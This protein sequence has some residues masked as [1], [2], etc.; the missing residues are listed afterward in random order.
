MNFSLR[1]ESA[2]D[3]VPL[4]FAHVGHRH[5]E[6]SSY[7][8]FPSQAP[9]NDGAVDALAGLVGAEGLTVQGT[10]LKSKD[11]HLSFAPRNLIWHGGRSRQLVKLPRSV[12]ADVSGVAPSRSAI[13]SAIVT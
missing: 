1:F 8:S 11:D 9:I 4:E 6:P 5:V 13:K 10:A 3:F 2:R 12:C 7:G